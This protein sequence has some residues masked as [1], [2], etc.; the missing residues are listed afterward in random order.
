[1]TSVSKLNL[2]V[3]ELADL[4]RSLWKAFQKAEKEYIPPLFHPVRLYQTSIQ[5]HRDRA[6]ALKNSYA[7]Y[8][9]LTVVFAIT[10][11][12]VSLWMM[13][14]YALFLTLAIFNKD[15]YCEAFARHKLRVSK[16]PSSAFGLNQPSLVIAGLFE[17]SEKKIAPQALQSLLKIQKA[18][19]D[20]ADSGFGVADKI[21]GT[22]LGLPLIAVPWLYRNSIQTFEAFKDSYTAAMSNWAIA[23]TLLSVS[24]LMLMF[25][26]DLLFGQPMAKRKRKRYILVLTLIAENYGSARK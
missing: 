22:L 17:L 18:S 12:G 8:I 9:V 1:M 11:V 19:G 7:I 6:L 2:Q 14:P 20:L 4:E 24:V 26:F 5:L 16:V 3:A 15:K 13:V 23:I 25:S 10:A 21:K